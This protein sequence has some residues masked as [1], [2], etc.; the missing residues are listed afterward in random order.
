MNTIESSS[1]SPL[2][3]L[4]AAAVLL[5]VLAACQAAR[6][7]LPEGL[8]AAPRMHVE[9]RQGW[10]I[11]QRLRFGPYEAHPVDRSWT[12]GRDVRVLT[13]GRSRR[14]QR[15]AFTLREQGREPWRVECEAFL[16][17]R[18]VDLGVVQVEP[19]NASALDCRLRPLGGVGEEWWMVLDEEGERPLRGTLQD[20]ERVLDVVGTNR[21][22]RALPVRST[23]GYRIAEEE[24][25]LAAVE[26]VNDGAVWLDPGLTPAERSPLAAA[27]AAL[28]L[29]EDLRE[30]LPE[31]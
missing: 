2:R 26:V 8:R 31:R 22:E 20:G 16:R 19:E 25:D 13:V 6:T 28:L 14:R 27:T 5:A 1:R 18:S 17:T 12:R 3:P 24:R 21:L 29:L 30:T 10:K 23:T 4:G 9:G 11:D 15:Y 7:P